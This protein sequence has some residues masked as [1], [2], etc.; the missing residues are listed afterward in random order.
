M[1]TP[2]DLRIE[3]EGGNVALTAD[4]VVTVLSGFLGGCYTTKR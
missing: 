1:N 3:L 2:T 4:D